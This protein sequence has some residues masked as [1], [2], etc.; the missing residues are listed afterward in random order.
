MKSFR[1]Y[2]G[3]IPVLGLPA[4]VVGVAFF[5]LCELRESGDLAWLRRLPAG[6]SGWAF[7]L[8]FGLVDT[9]GGHPALTL[10]ILSVAALW[11]CGVNAHRWKL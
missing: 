5:L 6:Q 8:L 10:L 4:M 3:I 1:F 2:L 7:R 11:L 9:A